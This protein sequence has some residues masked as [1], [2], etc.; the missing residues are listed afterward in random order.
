MKSINPEIPVLTGQDKTIA[1]HMPVQTKMVRPGTKSG[2]T[3]YKNHKKIVLDNGPCTSR[4]FPGK[5]P[6]V[7]TNNA[8]K[9]LLLPKLTTTQHRSS[10]DTTQNISSTITNKFSR[11]NALWVN[12]P[13][14]IQT[15]KI[16]TT[17]RRQ[18]PWH[19]ASITIQGTTTLQQCQFGKYH[20]RATS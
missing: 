5:A 1:R 8:Q 11:E 13:K 14:L 4:L 9:T 19:T 10:P 20:W 15:R 17:G 16:C 6:P 3:Q 12:S 18:P 7:Q 2:T